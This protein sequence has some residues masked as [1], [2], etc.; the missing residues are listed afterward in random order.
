MQG[1]KETFRWYGP[2]D[3][4]SLSSI[5]Q[6]GCTGVMTSLH[7]YP[8]GAVW[9]RDDIA[10]RKTELGEFD[11][12]W[13]AVESV[14]VSEAIKTQSGDFK[15]HIE[16]YKQTIRN[17]GA[18]GIQTV[19]YNFMPVLDW[20]RT[21]LAYRLKD[22]TECLY[23]DPIKFAA[24]EIFLLKRT[25][26]ENDYSA[27][28]LQQAK[29]L[30]D[31]SS[32][33]EIHALERSLIDVFPG[34]SFN[35]SIEDVRSM[36]AAYAE[37]DRDKLKA[38][39]N[40]FLKEVIPVCEEA[41]VQMAIH[42]DD[43]PYSVLG[44]PRIVSCE[45][46]LQDIIAMHDS[47]ANGLCFCSGSLGVRADNDLPHIIKRLGHRINSVHL[48]SV[49]RNAD[50]SFFEANHLEGSVDMYAVIDSLLEEMDR[51]KSSGRTDWQ[52][53]FRP[54]HGHTMLDD[55]QKPPT[56]NPGYSCIGRMRGLAEIRG[57]QLGLIRSK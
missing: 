12:E 15:Q 39:L 43:P 28:Q 47:P 19:I 33:A 2:N 52:L 3:P 1:L 57:L 24:F 9:T 32:Q 50:G 53:S 22:G 36:L 11:L 7:H 34:K 14:P 10:Q 26:A 17:L 30:F 18:E 16:N 35:Y 23:Y 45:A 31:R 41:G 25:G 4:V 56:P 42:P 38:H 54:D 51:R 20:I 46:D 21:D 37:I 49:Q 40:Y 27:E 44:L 8:Y 6:C 13:S 5:R 29:L 55:L 48:R